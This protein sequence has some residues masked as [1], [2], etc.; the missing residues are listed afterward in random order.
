MQG[1]LETNYQ[2]NL[3]NFQKLELIDNTNQLKIIEISKLSKEK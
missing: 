2:L 1:F 3:K